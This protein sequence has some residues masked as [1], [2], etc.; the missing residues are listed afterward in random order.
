MSCRICG[1]EMKGRSDKKYC[2]PKCKSTNKTL[3]T[4]SLMRKKWTVKREYGITLD[5]Y[6]LMMVHQSDRCAICLTDDKGKNDFWCIDH[7][8]QT[9]KVRGLLCDTCNRG[10]GL[11][12]DDADNLLSASKYLEASK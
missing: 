4:T 1:V 6:N 12:G 11:L 3:T 7:D 8:H 5:D 9:G 10:I 2:S